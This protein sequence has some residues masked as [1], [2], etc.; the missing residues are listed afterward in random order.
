ML[1]GVFIEQWLLRMRGDELFLP[2]APA[3]FIMTDTK[4]IRCRDSLVAN[5]AIAAATQLKADISR[6]R[7][8][9]RNA[10]IVHEKEVPD[11]L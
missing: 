5:I 3:R 10:T 11:R 1:Q 8:T 4:T 7:M 2:F 9:K 6:R